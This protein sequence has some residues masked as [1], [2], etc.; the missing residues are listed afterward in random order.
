MRIET[1]GCSGGIGDD[2]HT[3]AFLIDDDI[4]LDAGSG[5]LRLSRAALTRIDHVFITHCHLDHILALPLLL[6]SVASERDRPL[7][8]HAMPEVLEILKDHIFNWRIW[9]D[10][11][12]IPSVNQAFLRYEPISMGQTLSLPDASGATR[13]ITP[14]PAFHV[15]PTSGYLLRGPL[16]SVLFSSD[17]RGHPA[18]WEIAER[19]PDLR[20]LVV[21]CSYA[22][23][24]KDIAIASRHF[25]TDELAADLA[26]LKNCPEV[27]IAHMKPGAEDQIMRELTAAVPADASFALHPLMQD[28]ILN[29]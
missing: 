13:E 9:P 10:F 29:I 8:L 2:R 26:G 20:H 22:S 11:S 21:D 5:A 27:W 28:Q 17:T 15:V 16:G 7:R 6:D 24:Q 1:L 19:Q 14:I 3:T 18:L 4:L 23:A 12:R 25:Y